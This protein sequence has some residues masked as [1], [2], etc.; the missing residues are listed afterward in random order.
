M[1]NHKH[2]FIYVRVTKTASHSLLRALFESEMTEDDKWIP[3]ETK[4]WDFPEADIEIKFLTDVS[5]VWDQDKKH[6]PLSIVKKVTSDSVYNSYFK[7]AFVR[8]PF[9]K[10]VSAYAYTLNWYL[11]NDP[12][13]PYC[14]REFKEWVQNLDVNDKY[15]FQHTYVDGCDFVGRFENLQLDF[16]KICDKIKIPHQQLPHKNSSKHRHYTEYYDEETK[17]IVAE[18]YAKDIEMFGYEFG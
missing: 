13:S 8:N 16:N 6:Y 14:P 5:S 17:Q 1:I 15:G 2:K 4:T 11:E 3:R 18:K 10:L 7:F 12:S 9:D